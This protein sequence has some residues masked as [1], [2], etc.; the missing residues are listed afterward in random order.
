MALAKFQTRIFDSPL[1]LMQFVQT[2]STIA[3]VISIC[4]DNGGKYVLFYLT[5]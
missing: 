2:D 5:S 4:S 3:S 1:A